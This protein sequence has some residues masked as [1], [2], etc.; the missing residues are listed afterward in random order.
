ML[1]THRLAPGQL[2]QVLVPG[3]L[4]HV[5]RDDGTETINA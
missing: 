1:K 3:S 2:R 5:F 4:F